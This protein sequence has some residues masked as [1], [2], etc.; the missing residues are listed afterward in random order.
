[1]PDS[2]ITVSEA[3]V[4][5]RHRLVSLLETNG[6]PTDGVRANPEWFRVA[7]D[8]DGT[9]VGGGGV[10]IHG[11]DGLLRSVV[12]R[13]SDRGRGYGS[14]LCDELEDFA[15]ENDVETC[16]LLTTTAGSFF[17]ERGYEEIDRSAV[18]ERIRATTEFTDLC[19]SSATCLR[20][21]L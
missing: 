21:S 20:K 13:E 2:S 16:Y 11:T 8:A 15:R 14:V 18:P 3:D 12:V 7:T 17:R 19:P 1:M 6:L 5:D 9:V 10:E 4:S